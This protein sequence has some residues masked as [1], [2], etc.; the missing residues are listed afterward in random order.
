MNRS[1]F[2]DKITIIASL[3]GI[4]ISLFGMFFQIKTSFHHSSEFHLMIVT[5]VIAALAG[6]FS[7]QIAELIN[8]F[9]TTKRI[10][11]SYSH[12][13]QET[14][15]EIVDQ[16]RHER[17]KIWIDID[18]I[19]P[20]QVIQNEIYYAMEETDILLIFITDK[21]SYWTGEEVN[22]AIMKGK[23]IIPVITDP[24]FLPSNLR[25]YKCIKMTDDIHQT[26]VSIANAI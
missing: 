7:R 2:V 1:S 10:F 16:I 15:K 4:I 14:V 13:F 18:R 20:G 8:K 3:F 9:V 22:L 12:Q 24:E 21:E 26:A 25:R 17:R 11:V 19:K 5:I 23:R 6:L